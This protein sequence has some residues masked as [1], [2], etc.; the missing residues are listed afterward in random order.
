MIP[1]HRFSE[2]GVE[3]IK[4]N[5]LK[6]L[7]NYDFDH[8]HRHDYFEFFIFLNGGGIH[9]IDF[10]EFVIHP[11][12]IHIVAPGQVHQVKRALNSTGFVLLFNT[13]VFQTN[14]LIYNFLF[15]HICHDIN[16]NSPSYQFEANLQEEVSKIANQIWK[17][18]STETYLK[19]EFVL[20]NLNLLCI[21]CERS[22]KQIAQ[23]E[24]SN[25]NNTTYYEFRRMVLLNYKTIKKVTDY[26]LALNISEKQL[27]EVVKSK[28]GE[29][30]STI[31]FKQIV[32]EAKRLL[33]TGISVKEVAFDLNFDDPAH[34]S[35][36]F[37]TQT[38]ISP[39]Q[40]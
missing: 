10:E 17:D 29:S 13:S 16:E 7:N 1:I 32:L 33:H 4:V 2:K 15:N 27:N 8:P 9:S 35:K 30:A 11:N 14:N 40:L 39:S 36:F 22:K 38:G 26:A 25:K 37:K 18:Y 21:F 31:I 20:S 3:E 28:T 23:P 6:T 5:E 12:S 34:F 19:N 24:S